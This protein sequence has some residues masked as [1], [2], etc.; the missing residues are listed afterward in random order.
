MIWDNA[1]YIVAL[2]TPSLS[3]VCGQVNN[4]S[5]IKPVLSKIRLELTLALGQSAEFEINHLILSTHI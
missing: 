5:K 3:V 2:K 1:D 4:I